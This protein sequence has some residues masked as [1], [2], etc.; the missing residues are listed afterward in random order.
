MVLPDSAFTSQLELGSQSALEE[1]MTL[2][3]PEVTTLRAAIQAGIN[4]GE[5]RELEALIAELRDKRAS[6]GPS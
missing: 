4:S 6:Q 3:E 1:P 2:H 5:G